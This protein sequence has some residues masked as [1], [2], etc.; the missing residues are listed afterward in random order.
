MIHIQALFIGSLVLGGLVALAWSVVTFVSPV[1]IGVTASACALIAI[2]YT[3][4]YSIL[5]R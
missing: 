2:A 5:Y 4:G 3:V 1:A